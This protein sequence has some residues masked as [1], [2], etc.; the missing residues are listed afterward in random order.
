MH[1]FYTYFR[2]AC[3]AFLFAFGLSQ[4]TPEKH[5]VKHTVSDVHSLANI[6]QID[7]E[8]MY[9]NLKV[10]FKSHQLEAYVDLFFHQTDETDSI[11]LDT[12]DLQINRVE[13]LNGESLAFNLAHEVELL[14][15]RLAIP[16]QHSD[17]FIRI[18]YT[19]SNH[20]AALQF[21]EVPNRSPFMFTQSQ[22]ILARSWV[23]CMDSPGKKFTYSADVQV[24]SG[25]I[26]LMS[27]ENP[28]AT[29][30]KGQYHFEMNQAIS[31]YLLALAVGKF[32]YHALSNNCG[33][34]AE[35]D[36]L[37]KAVWEFNDLPKMIA[38]AEELYGPYRWGKYDVLV[39]PP[40]FPFG[41]MENPRLT[42]ATPTIITGDRSLTALLAHEL[43]HS[44]SG[45]LVSNE[46]WN[47]FWL[48]EGFTMYFENR[49]MEK[50]YGKEYADMLEFNGF[51]EMQAE[52][53]TMGDS[54]P[55]TRLKLDLKDKDPDEAVNAVA[56]EK[57]RFFLRCIEDNV[58]RKNW[59]NFLTNYFNEN[60]F[61]AMNTENFMRILQEKLVPEN[62]NAW[63][64]IQA[65]K[66]LYQPGIPSNC[67]R[68]QPTSFLLIDSLEN[69]W[70][71]GKIKTRQ[72]IHATNW[73]THKWQYFLRNLQG[74]I[75]LNQLMDLDKTFSF[76]QSRNA[77]ILCDWFQLCIPLNYKIAEAPCRN[78]LINI[79]RRKFLIP[80]YESILKQ[81]NGKEKAMEI[82]SEAQMNYHPLAQHSISKLIKAAH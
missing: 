27:A 79:G 20:A 9:L 32:S 39:L 38:S 62:S 33:I 58:G 80:I 61:H 53:H 73:D 15:S 48:N 71:C 28:I 10:N 12:R 67:P 75:S 81:P 68:V 46:T 23:P 30:E 18:Y 7:V 43:A 41:G 50:I 57:G 1:K 65:D 17:T 70:L 56:Y 69:G 60:A 63:N 55:D 36:M 6:N 21:V 40:A 3:F 13:N 31:S 8:H 47:D 54:S 25:L 59:D 82:Y 4:C 14:G 5:L 34:Y 77:E 44:W 37:P 49:I 22:A 29:N 64:K 72:L 42:F 26:A 52:L 45:N 16:I 78:F 24:D 76:T 2:Y 19:T 35:S 74:I 11:C 66:W 51:K